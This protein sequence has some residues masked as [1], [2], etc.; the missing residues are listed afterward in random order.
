MVLEV[1]TTQSVDRLRVLYGAYMA[2]GE[3]YLMQS[4]R[5]NIKQWSEKYPIVQANNG[6]LIRMETNRVSRQQVFDTFAEV[7]QLGTLTEA[8][9][10]VMAW[11]FTPG[12]YGT[13]R[14]NAMLSNPRNGRTVQDVLESAAGNSDPVAAYG[15]L[16][17]ALEQLGPAF[18]TKFLYFSSQPENRAPIFDMVVAQWLWRYGVRDAKGKWISPVG[19]NTK[20]YERYV[21]FCSEI[22]S[23]LGIIDR[24]LVEY[25]MFVDSQYSE[26]LERGKTQVMW[27]T[28]AEPLGWPVSEPRPTAF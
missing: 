14:T 12:R 10:A 11:G 22:C 26:Y 9:V 17:N 21:N 6:A 25:L 19:W 16:A 5:L 8:F 4:T 3:N 1:A 2:S 15:E 7:N 23:H 18:G 28:S 24:G 27:I 20:L 13:F